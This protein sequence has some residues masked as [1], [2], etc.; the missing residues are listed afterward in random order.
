MYSIDNKLKEKDITAFKDFFVKH[1]DDIYAY[2]LNHLKNEA[3]A[4]DV[5]Q[6][7]FIRFWEKLESLQ[8]DRNLKSYLYTIAKNI[9]FEEFRK[10]SIFIKYSNHYQSINEEKCN[11]LEELQNFK[12]LKILYDKAIG[13]LP[14]KRREIYQLS[15]IYN[16]KN[17][18]IS[19]MLNISV[20]TVR[21][22]LVKSSKSIKMFI[23]NKLTT[24][25]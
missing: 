6:D 16:Y 14:E 10:Q 21:D 3:L 22:Q 7:T 12:E 9:V 2:A 25:F 13:S 24:F 18:E 19:S 23:K 1:S 4:R 15:K 5:V 11:S 8:F 20:N 17:E